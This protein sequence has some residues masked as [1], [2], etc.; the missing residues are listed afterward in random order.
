MQRRGCPG[1][2]K[3]SLTLTELPGPFLGLTEL[4]AAQC[5]RG[6]HAAAR[7]IPARCLPRGLNFNGATLQI[8]HQVGRHVVSGAQL[9]G[10]GGGMIFSFGRYRE[11]VC[12]HARS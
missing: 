10:Y 11:G 3:S 6:T 7:G 8:L 12:W 5:L 9:L 1:V 2:L 4:R